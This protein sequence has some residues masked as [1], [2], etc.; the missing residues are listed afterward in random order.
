MPLRIFTVMKLRRKLVYS[1]TLRI[2]IR[3]VTG[4]NFGWNTDRLAQSFSWFSSVFRSFKTVIGII[5]WRL[6]FTSFSIQQSLALKYLKPV[7][8]VTKKM[9]SPIPV[10]ARSKVWV[11]SRFLVGIAGSIPQGAWLSVFFECCVLSGR[12]LCVKLI[13]RPEGSYRQ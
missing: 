6:S 3:E 2:C 11:Y 8:E 4:Q 9:A 13:T 5:P 7:S 1:S 10:A 12:G